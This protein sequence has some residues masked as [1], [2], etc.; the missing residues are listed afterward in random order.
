[1][2]ECATTSSRSR[3]RRSPPPDRKPILA[4]TAGAA[5]INAA[6]KR[7]KQRVKSTQRKRNI[8]NPDEEEDGDEEVGS[9]SS[10]RSGS[11]SRSRSGSGSG[12]SD[13]DEENRSSEDED[14][15]L[16]KSA[17]VRR[18]ANPSKRSIRTRRQITGTHPL[19]CYLTI[20]EARLLLE[21]SIALTKNPNGRLKANKKVNKDFEQKCKNLTRFLNIGIMDTDDDEPSNSD[22]YYRRPRKVDS[23]PDYKPSVSPIRQRERSPTPPQTAKMSRPPGKTPPQTAKMSRPGKKYPHRNRR[24]PTV[25]WLSTMKYIVRMAE[26]GA[27]EAKIRAKYNW[28]RSEDLEDL[29]EKIASRERASNGTDSGSDDSENDDVDR[30]P[31]GIRKF[32][33]AKPICKTET[34]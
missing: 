34:H 28:Y 16:E 19:G 23:D 13:L 1:M 33:F 30:K 31:K 17:T 15:G 24:W 9:S 27:T 4:T 6:Q 11:R 29:R 18:P 32:S 8:P 3:P 26:E 7:V 25:L 21:R 22:I 5:A 20:D 14:S 12:A 10:S 2:R